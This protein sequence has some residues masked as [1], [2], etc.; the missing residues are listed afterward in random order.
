MRNGQCNII[1]FGHWC[2]ILSKGQ[3]CITEEYNSGWVYCITEME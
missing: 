2:I 1:K 3:H